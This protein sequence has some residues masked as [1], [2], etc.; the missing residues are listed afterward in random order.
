MI[1]PIDSGD[2]H[3]VGCGPPVAEHDVAAQEVETSTRGDVHTIDAIRTTLDQLAAD[4]TGI[5]A[6]F[7]ERIQYDNAKEEAFDR[8]YRQLDEL[9]AGREFDHLR[10]LYI[11]LILLFDRLDQSAAETARHHDAGTVAATLLSLREELVEILYRREIELI[12]YSST[13]FD[14]KWQRAIGTQDTTAQEQDNTIGIV[15][16]RGF[17]F[18]D[19]LIRPE[20][21]VLNK[22]R[23]QEP[24]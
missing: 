8:L 13:K 15:V 11:D 14:P 3:D 21:V 17:R 18:G 10:P 23:Q 1:E 7:A 24:S 5:K 22:C 16:R 9:R 12:S 20:E 4:I 2:Q 6:V 19:R